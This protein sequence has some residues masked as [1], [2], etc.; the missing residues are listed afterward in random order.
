MQEFGGPTAAGWLFAATA[1][2]IAVGGAASGWIGR[3]HRQGLAL[4]VSVVVWEVAVAAAGAA[5]ESSPW[6][7]PVGRAWAICAPVGSRL[8]SGCGRPG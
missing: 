8:W 2:A 3:V 5:A 1:I 6:W 7:W 4:I